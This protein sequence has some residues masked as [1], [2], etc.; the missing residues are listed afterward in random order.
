MTVKKFGRLS[1]IA[2]GIASTW[3]QV[4]AAPVYEIVSIKD[5][6]LPTLNGTRNNYAMDVNANGEVVGVAKGRNLVVSSSEAGINNPANGIDAK[7]TVANTVDKPFIGN[8]FT[9]NATENTNWEITFEPILDATHPEQTENKNTTDTVFFGINDN[10][11]KV[12]TT[13]AVMKTLDKPD[14]ND[15]SKWYYRDYE[16]R[17]F[18]KRNSDIRELTPPF[19]EYN[20]AVVGGYSIAADI[21]ENNLI[22]GSASI[23]LTTGSKAEIDACI[24]GNS[25]TA[26]TD[27]CIQSKQ[28]PDLSGQV[29]VNYQ[30]RAYQW[31]LTSSGV[32]AKQLPYPFQIAEGDTFNYTSQALGVNDYGE[33]VGRSYVRRANNNLYLDAVYWDRAGDVQTIPFS[34]DKRQSIANAI[35]NNGILVGNYQSYISGYLR[36]KFFY[37]NINNPTEGTVEPLDF[38]ASRSDLSSNPRSINNNNVVVGNIDIDQEKQK[39]RRKNAFYYEIDNKKFHN[40]NDLLTC[41]SKGFEKDNQ[42]N[43][44]RHQVKVEDSNGTLLSYNTEIVVVEAVK[45]QDDGTITGTALITKPKVQLDANGFPVVDASGNPTFELNGRGQPTTQQIARQVVLRPTGDQ[46]CSIQDANTEYPTFKR[47]GANAWWMIALLPLVFFR[48]RK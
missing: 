6:D 37:F 30:N 33:T 22:V 17:G 16:T 9:F 46:A 12:G 25:E 45:I 36:N 8:N 11:F 42:G 15:D 24:N 23:D 39:D 26:P 28:L 31:Q 43:W 19:T 5:Y 34:D 21:N 13:S 18:S 41:E 38:F 1:A 48:R 2:F 32:V 20:G 47:K 7:E 10:G 27:I 29:K 44:V 40:L 35:N 3:G 14:S 4:Q